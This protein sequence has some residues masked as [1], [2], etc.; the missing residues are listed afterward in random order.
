MT[1]IAKTCKYPGCTEP[2]DSASTGG[3]PTAYC[4][5]PEHNRKSAFLARSAA[6]APGAAPGRPG[7]VE[8]L[9]TMLA[10]WLDVIEDAEDPARSQQAI[11]A[12]AA[13][14]NARAAQSAADLEQVRADLLAAQTDLAAEQQRAAELEAAE[15]GWRTTVSD[16]T[17]DLQARTGE[18]ADAEQAL[19]EMTK[20]R[21]SFERLLQQLND[22]AKV[23]ED[24]LANERARA[25]AAGQREANLAAE[26]K[27]LDG[28]LADARAAASKEAAA[29]AGHETRATMLEEQVRAAQAETRAEREKSE[30]TVQ[31][32]RAEAAGLH[33]QIAAA[34]EQIGTLAAELRAA[35]K[36]IQRLAAATK[37]EVKR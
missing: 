17:D 33:D 27:K 35:E 14:A 4:A 26:L 37:P 36:E 13:A 12:A 21:D 2:V 28:A 32:E 9:R 22:R 30:T 1:T 7:T 23:V 15:Q 6:A 31:R 10:A 8:E 20:E 5:D 18:L 11:A 34:K 29:A 24:D 25:E 3:R 19:A 16:L